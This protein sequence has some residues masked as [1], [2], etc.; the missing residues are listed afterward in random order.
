MTVV[1][2]VPVSVGGVL[3][4]AASPVS[5]K[6]FVENICL[7]QDRYRLGRFHISPHPLP[8]SMTDSRFDCP[9]WLWLLPSGLSQEPFASI[10]SYRSR[11][12]G[13]RSDRH[14]NDLRRLMHSL[15]SG[16]SSPRK[17]VQC[18]EMRRN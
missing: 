8:Q 17:S 12:I 9:R 16:T 14:L 10:N 3:A 2:P 6:L 5:K 18:R 15:L 13:M 4:S 7:G 11:L 1:N